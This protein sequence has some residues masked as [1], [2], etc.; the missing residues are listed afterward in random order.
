MGEKTP[1]IF[2]VDKQKPL[3]VSVL[4]RDRQDALLGLIELQKASQKL[5]PHVRNRSPDRMPGLPPN[6]PEGNWGGSIL[7]RPDTDLYRP[8]IKLVV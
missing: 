6:V 2:E 3:I 5:R 7:D 1:Q 8:L 4:K